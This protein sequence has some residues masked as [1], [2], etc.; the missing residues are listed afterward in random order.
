M[1]VVRVASCRPNPWNRR[2]PVDPDLRDSI[3]ECGL[4]QPIVVREMGDGFEIIAGERRWMAAQDLGLEYIAATIL[5][6]DDLKARELALVENCQRENLTPFEEA[7]EITVLLELHHDNVAEVAARLGRSRHYV[8][9]RA[10]LANLDPGLFEELEF[11]PEN[12]PVSC[13]ELL[14]KL[15][16][17]IQKAIAEETP[18]A[19]TNL[20]RLESAVQGLTHRVK[21]APF[22]QADCRACPKRT[23][24][25]PDLFGG[26]SAGIGAEDRCLDRACYAA[27]EREF[28][29]AVVRREMAF[30]GTVALVARDIPLELYAEAKAH[31][32]G[33][34]D[35][36]FRAEYETCRKDDAGA[37]KGVIWCGEGVGKALFVRKVASQE[38]AIPLAERRWAWVVEKVCSRLRAMIAELRE[39]DRGTVQEIVDQIYGGNGEAQLAELEE[40]AAEAIGK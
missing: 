6:A 25:D 2:R 20:Y 16:A 19:I 33:I 26:S 36:L 8:R 15:P 32:V 34:L 23:G 13:Q 11:G 35:A 30:D 31:K 18:F 22:D 29:D 28:V 12:I 40:Q 9:S 10:R 7:K 14:A 3:K 17:D 37:M 27:K 5:E 1:S 4:L 24:F 38:D 39:G 21:F